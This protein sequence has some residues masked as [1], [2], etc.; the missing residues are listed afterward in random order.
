MVC[1]PR[2]ALLVSTSIAARR[3][4]TNRYKQ[5]MPTYDP[6]SLA[7]LLIASMAA[8]YA[9]F[10]S[11]EAA[12]ANA[13]TFRTEW[14]ATY[15]SMCAARQ[16]FTRS[17]SPFSKLT[18]E[19]RRGYPMP[20]EDVLAGQLIEL[21]HLAAL[22]KDDRVHDHLTE[23]LKWN[24][25]LELNLDICS[26][27]E[28]ALTQEQVAELDREAVLFVDNARRSLGLAIDIVREMLRAS[29]P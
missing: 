23:A 1:Q 24:N 10:A 16:H 12:R 5:A 14:L 8:A 17:T 15:K 20:L 28:G 13:L 2:E 19:G 6:L 7:S 29:A 18:A 3:I 21:S 22:W 4:S 26:S 27:S 25:Q 9:R 11:K